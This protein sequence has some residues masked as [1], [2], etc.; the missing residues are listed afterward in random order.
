MFLRF[1]ILAIA[2]AGLM[3][4]SFTTFDSSRAQVSPDRT[5]TAPK[6]SPTPPPKDEDEVIKI[7]TEVVNVLFT[8]QDRNRRL[9]TSL[10]QDDIK[11]IENGQP[12]QLVAFSRQVDLP[13]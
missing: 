4:V 8:A 13:L 3:F 7:D 11:I 5:A 9:L 12:Q 6:P 1:R 2:A 10:R